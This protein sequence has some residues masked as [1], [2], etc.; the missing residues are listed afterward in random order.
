M[1]FYKVPDLMSAIELAIFSSRI[2]SICDEMGAMLQR[3]AFSPNIKDR[4]DFSCAIF[5]ARGELVAQAAHIPVHLGS[6]AFAMKDVVGA[7]KWSDSDVV[8]YNDPYLGGTHLPD[9][10]LVSP[11]I[12]DGCVTA[13]CACRAH[14]ANIGASS[15]GS[16]PVSSHLDEEG[17]L[18]SPMKLFSGGVVVGETLKLLLQISQPEV[19][20][21]DL[22]LAAKALQWESP[23]KK[24]DNV[25]TPACAADTSNTVAEAGLLIA[26]GDF[27]A[28]L[29]A[30][31][32]G[33]Q[34]L[35]AN[36]RLTG[37]AA[38]SASVE[39]LNAYASAM[40]AA[41]LQSIPHGQAFFEDKMDG[42][43]IEDSEVFLKVLVTKNADRILFDF[44]GTSLQVKGNINCPLSVTAAAVFYVIRCLLPPQLP[45]CAGM[46]SCIDIR[47]EKGSLLNAVYP[48]AVAAGNVET[49]SRIVDVVLGALSRLMPKM[50]PAASQGTMNNV[51]MGGLSTVRG[52]WDY[53]ET[54]CGGGGAHAKGPGLNARHTHMTNTLNTP[55][56]SLESHYPLRVL[57]YAM[58]EKSGGCGKFS[59]GNGV[60]RTYQFLEDTTVTLLTERRFSEPWGLAGAG[61]GARGENLLNGKLLPSK[62]ASRVRRNDVLTIKT[63]GGGGYGELIPE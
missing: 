33:A 44:S 14:H 7:F 49:S 27:M 61:N 22:L 32:V 4:L 11:V 23:S 24:V 51:A 25:E 39:K 42:D 20:E 30:V 15:P 1:T 35:L 2:E 5:D 12:I 43:G 36:I 8:I 52:R 40:T 54:I 60:I 16:M 58:R 9:V 18:I 37:R 50:I 48:G 29:G 3:A 55:I 6:M 57:E 59:G 10:T 34:R 53:Y 26:L 45:A 56:E 46:F 38:F 63:P 47:A 13:F 28:Q 41:M 62:F 31:N 19:S 17:V 21:E